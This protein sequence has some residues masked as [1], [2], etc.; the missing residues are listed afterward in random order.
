MKKIII[1][2]FFILTGL[3]QPALSNGMPY[4]VTNPPAGHASY[5]VI[6]KDSLKKSREIALAFATE[7]LNVAGSSLEIMGSEKTSSAGGYEQAIETIY[8]GEETDAVI[9]NDFT[10]NE[11]LC[12]LVTTSK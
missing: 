7:E 4:W 2:L 11:E 3:N 8:L 9:V 1:V 10:L 6:V 12:V 5:C